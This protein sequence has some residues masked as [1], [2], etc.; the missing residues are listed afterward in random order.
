MR[1]QLSLK[2]NNNQNMGAQENYTNFVEFHV[3][4]TV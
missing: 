1:P 2:M 4:Q 3:V